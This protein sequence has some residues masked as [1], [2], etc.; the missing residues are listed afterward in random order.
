[1]FLIVRTVHLSEY[2]ES[3]S[4]LSRLLAETNQSESDDEADQEADE[5]T[6]AD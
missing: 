2:Y 6:N 1:M 4:S 3:F 5:P